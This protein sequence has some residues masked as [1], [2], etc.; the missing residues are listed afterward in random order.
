VNSLEAELRATR[1]SLNELHDNRGKE[2]VR[3]TQLQLRTDNLLEHVSRRYQ[4][5]LREFSRTTTPSRRR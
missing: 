5:D 3:Q 4:L 1:N 2:Q